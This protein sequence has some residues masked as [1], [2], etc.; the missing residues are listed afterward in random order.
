MNRQIN[1]DIQL[2][3][4]KMSRTELSQQVAVSM[5]NLSL[6]KTAGKL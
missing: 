2:A 5:T 6:L 3:K 4:N 1:L